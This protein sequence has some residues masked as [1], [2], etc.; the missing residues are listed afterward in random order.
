[1]NLKN[2]LKW[3]M[4]V[5]MSV[6]L[7]FIMLS[8]VKIEDIISTLANAN[9]LYLA[10]FFLLYVL[11]MVLR[12]V[13]FTMVLKNKMSFRQMLP[14]VLL[15]NLL[16][17]LIPF[18]IGELSYIYYVKKIG[19]QSYHKGIST[20]V[21]TKVFDLSILIIF[22][23]ISV[24]SLHLA[25]SGFG[26]SVPYLVALLA[27]MSLA[28]ILLIYQ[29]GIIIRIV[30]VFEKIA[31]KISTRLS[32]FTEQVKTLVNSFEEF[33][34]P[35]MLAAIFIQSVLIMSVSMACF[36]FT[37]NALGFSI[38]LNVLIIGSTF[39][40][41]SNLIPVNGIAG[42]GTVEGV[43]VLVLTFFGY[44]L[45]SAIVLSFSLHIIQLISISIM[46]S[47]GWLKLNALQS[48]EKAR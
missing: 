11:L 30:E 37:V 43:W 17:N 20:L 8:R 29:Q 13:R 10:I 3:T 36:Y 33:K 14:V 9:L 12:T 34:S 28:L 6:F 15:Q 25:S 48:S 19:K 4:A 45:E 5:A 7:V 42:F 32:F 44:P 31:L 18:R 22:F 35:K 27:L 39:G 2:I 41:L 38:P 23:V 26:Q 1:M 46:G 40:V 16:L 24:F 21:I 47:V